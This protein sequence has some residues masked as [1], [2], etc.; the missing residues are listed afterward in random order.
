MAANQG[1]LR[2]GRVFQFFG[3]STLA[4]ARVSSGGGRKTGIGIVRDARLNTLAQPPEPAIFFAA[5]ASEAPAPSFIL[6]ARIDPRFLLRSIT[7]ELARIHP[8]LRKSLVSTLRQFMRV[9]LRSQRETMKLLGWLGTL[10][11]GLTILGIYGTM[12]SLVTQ[13]TREIGI[14]MAVYLS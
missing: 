5:G 1:D 12:S 14:R 6:R 11:L 3:Y 9:P 10:A 13:W 8:G 4:A 7:A 2:F